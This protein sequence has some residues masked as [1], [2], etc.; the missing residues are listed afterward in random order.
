MTYCVAVLLQAGMVFGSDSRTNAGLDNFA[1]F[2]KMT[3]FERSGDR[4]LVLLSSGSLAGTQAVIS[5]LRQRA[6]DSNG[7]EN[8]WT[9]R[10]MFDVMVLVSDVVRKVQQRDAAYLEASGNGFNASFLVGGQIRGEA[11]RLFRMYAE[12]NFIEASADTPFL[13]T[14]EAKYGKPIIDRVI[15]ADTSLAEATK[16][17]LVS[18]DST[19]RSNLSVGMPID[20]IAYERDSLTITHRRRFGEGDAE[21]AELSSAWGVGVR[22]VFRDLPDVHW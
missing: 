13:Q 2:C 19:M 10:T 6:D 15:H 4:V 7:G 17:V 5:L 14:G 22:Q 16:C 9:A 18:F 11:P 1:T 21:F 20:L 8:L 12:G 3:V